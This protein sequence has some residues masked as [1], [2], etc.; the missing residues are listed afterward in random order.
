MYQ[1]KTSFILSVLFFV[2]S[3]KLLAQ[4]PFDFPER[5][6]YSPPGM[7][8]LDASRNVSYDY[9]STKINPL[10]DHHNF[11]K[12]SYVRKLLD[13]ANREL[14]SEVQQNKRI[15]AS[16]QKFL[17][18]ERVFA[19]AWENSRTGKISGV[20]WYSL[21][22]E[23]KAIHRES[24]FLFQKNKREK[25]QDSLYSDNEISLAWTKSPT[26]QKTGITWKELTEAERKFYRKR[27][28]RFKRQ[29]LE[30]DTLL[31]GSYRPRIEQVEYQK[32]WNSSRSKVRLGKDWHELGSVEKS[33]FRKLYAQ[34]K[35]T[36]MYD[37]QLLAS[38]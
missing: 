31:A 7:D 8:Q 10:R 3:F 33:K 30:Q 11:Q 27:Y 29:K 24:F 20:S 38:K 26:G 19:S 37:G 13:E 5:S 36:E 28:D 22:D 35:R 25:K 2:C 18:H 17:D 1:M 23:E 9:Q 34:A 16:R 21:S 6:N 4:S 14:F 32:A 15:R 12:S